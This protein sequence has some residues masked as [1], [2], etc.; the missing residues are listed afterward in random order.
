MTKHTPTRYKVTVNN[1]SCHGGDFDWTDYLPTTDGPGKWTTPVEDVVVC[2]YGYHL[3]TDVMRWPKVGMRVYEAEGTETDHV[4][5]DKSA[6]S[7]V[8]LLRDVTA[9]VVP[10]YWRDVETFVACL[11]DVPWMQPQGDPDPA[12]RVFEARG[13]VRA[14]LILSLHDS[15]DTDRAFAMDAVRSAA[16]SAGRRAARNEAIDTSQLS[17]LD[18]DHLVSGDA[19]LDACRSASLSASILVCP[20]GSVDQKHIDHINAR[21]DVWKRGYGLLCDVD[22]VL[23]VYRRPE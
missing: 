14:A 1:K 13:D 2:N 5:G 19:S 17:I 4:E 15:I 7:S 18:K 20:P 21:W 3:T 6:H 12:W 11:P 8:R 16:M 23:Y 22:G 10:Q 9:E